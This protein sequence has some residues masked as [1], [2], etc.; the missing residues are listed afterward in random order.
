M[1]YFAFAVI[2]P[3]AVAVL[4]DHVS[5]S[6]AAWMNSIV[7]SAFLGGQIGGNY[8]AHWIPPRRL[9]QVF[10]VLMT[11]FVGAAA[12]N[13]RNESLTETLLFIGAFAGGSADGVAITLSTVVI[14]DQDEIGA[15]GGIAGGTRSAGSAL[16]SVIYNTILSNMLSQN[17]A[18]LVSKRAIAAGLPTASAPALISALQGLTDTSK[19][20][21]LS[22]SILTAARENFRQANSK[23]FSTVFY[24]TIALNSI[25]M[26]CAMFIKAVDPARA[27]YVGRALQPIIKKEPAIDPEKASSVELH[28]VS[29]T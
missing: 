25:A 28:I 9:L 27:Q 7:G 12:A 8:L 3:S 26:I 21:G 15:A 17:L 5:P 29:D 20:P 10:T 1:T 13:L 24:A 16:G 19:V 2:W 14:V 23:S 11:I 22:D 18:K 6:R 4:Y